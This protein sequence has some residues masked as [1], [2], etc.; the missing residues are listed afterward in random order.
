MG[1]TSHD[2]PALTGME[3][4]PPLVSILVPIVHDD[5]ESRA[6]L[7][8]AHAQTW[9]AIEVIPVYACKE[10]KTESRAADSHCIVGAVEAGVAASRGDY[11]SLLLPGV[12]YEPHK[13]EAQVRF[14]QRLELHD[15]V[16]YCDYNDETAGGPVELPPLD[17]SQVFERLYCGLKLNPASFL[18]PRQFLTGVRLRK[19]S[20]DVALLDWSLQVSREAPFVG[21]AQTLLTVAVRDSSRDPLRRTVYKE[22]LRPLVDTTRCSLDRT[23]P[24]AVL[25]EAAAVRFVE[26][27][28]LAAVDALAEMC[29]TLPDVEH[30]YK[31]IAAFA[32]RF[33]RQ[34]Y[35]ALPS[36]VK[37]ALRVIPR[38][39]ASS[40]RDGR[41]DFDSIYRG[42]GF[43][44]TESLSGVGST[45]FQTRVVRR[46]LPILFKELAVRSVLDIPCGDFHWMREVDLGSVEYIGADVVEGLVRA[47]NERYRQPGRRFEV[48]DLIAG[49]LPAADLIF[50]RDCLVHLPIADIKSALQTIGDSG[51]TWLL[52]TTFL[53]CQHNRELDAAGW[54]ALNLER[55]PFN[56]PPPE[57]IILERCTE[58]GGR[59]ADKALGLWRIA[60]L[61]SVA[62]TSAA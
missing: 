33:A 18:V 24:F 9:R 7:Q 19:A 25:G 44:G 47:N 55:P 45:L 50:C 23:R 4:Q 15:A 59:A 1:H 35:R 2:G 56:L 6:R 32:R 26:R 38:R 52:T 17:P 13:I 39:R 14:M 20:V 41:L 28:P 46:E 12:L 43:V 22:A 62:H 21:M 53:E 42:N 5:E 34:S 30:K 10:P 11:V 37:T 54:R 29:R 61:R 8:N 36:A 3:H 40:L 58:A 27:Q 31:A 57:R 60:T 48:V 51:A 49:P 16:L